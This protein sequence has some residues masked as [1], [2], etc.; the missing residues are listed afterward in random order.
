MSR[1]MPVSM[2]AK[3]ISLLIGLFQV[4]EHISQGICVSQ[5]AKHISV[6]ISFSQVGE[7]ISLGICLSQVNGGKNLKVACKNPG[8]GRILITLIA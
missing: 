6:R 7:H 8:Y 4:E 2:V 3:H 1:G 5:V